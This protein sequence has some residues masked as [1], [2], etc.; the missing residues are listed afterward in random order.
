MI[1]DETRQALRDPE[2]VELPL[3]LPG[4]QVDAL[5]QVAADAHLTIG[6][7]LR[8]L[9]THSIAEHVVAR[10]EHVLFPDDR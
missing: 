9:V 5:E 8:R 7:Y 1:V 10:R 6:Q 2:M 4:W 3:L